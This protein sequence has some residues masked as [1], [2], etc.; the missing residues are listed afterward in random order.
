[1]RRT[2]RSEPS[3]R[4]TRP[5]ASV[6]STTRPEGAATS[7]RTVRGRSVSSQRS[8]A[9][10]LLLLLLLCG[11][12]ASRG[13]SR[14]EAAGAAWALSARGA[15]GVAVAASPCVHQQSGTPPGSSKGSQ[16]GGGAPTSPAL[17]APAWLARDAPPQPQLE[18]A[19]RLTPHCAATDAASCARLAAA[20]RARAPRDRAGAVRGKAYVVKQGSTE[21]AITP[22]LPGSQLL[23]V[24]T[25]GGCSQSSNRLGD[26]AAAASEAT[27]EW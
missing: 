5:C 1:M 6:D 15:A 23:E 7:W 10:L 26:R 11:G 2:A 16:R 3:S 18:R 24:G 17:P 4:R 25:H 20:S 19:A 8:S 9:S 12:R 13:G 21:A 14:C 27:R 22:G